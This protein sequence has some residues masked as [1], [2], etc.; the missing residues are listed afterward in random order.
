MKLTFKKIGIGLIIALG[1]FLALKGTI[2]TVIHFDNKVVCQQINPNGESNT[3]YIVPPN[4]VILKKQFNDQYEYGVFK[5]RGVNATHYFGPIYSKGESFLGWRIYSGATDVWKV[6]MELADKKGNLAESTFGEI[7][8]T[9]RDMIIFRDKS[10][11][12]GKY[13]YDQIN[14]SKE[15][16]DLIEKA[17]KGIK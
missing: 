17:T 3:I 7:G 12:I 11:E 1:L 2:I 9:F 14:L 6:E 4:T 10:V 5:A 8:E 15:D 16:E 13:T